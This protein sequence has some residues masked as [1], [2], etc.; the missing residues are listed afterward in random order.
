MIR[1]FLETI[2]LPGEILGLGLVPL[3]LVRKRNPVS[4]VAWCLAVLFIPY[5]GALFFLVFGASR[6]KRRLRRKLYHRSQFLRL[7]VAQRSRMEGGAAGDS[8]AGMSAYA[9]RVGAAPD[10]T[11]NAVTLYEEGVR[12][13]EDK[14]AAIRAAQ[15]HVHASYFIL[16][17]DAAGAEFMDLLCAK[18]S[19]GVEVRL[20]VDAV[21]SRGADHLLARLRAAGGRAAL[22]MPSQ[23]LSGRFTVGLRNHGKI[24]VCDG[25]VGFVGGLNVGDEYLGRVPRF[26]RWRDTHL[27]VAGPAVLALQRVF[28]ED[29]DFA[30]GELLTGDSYFPDPG[31]EGEAHVQVI[32]SGPDQEHNASRETFFA[33]ITAARRRLWIATPYLVPDGALLAAIRSAALRGV[34]VRILTQSSPPDHWMT[35]WAGRYFWEELFSAGV[36]IHEYRRGMMHAKV[37]L[38]DGAWACVGSANLDIRSIRLNFEINV[39]LHTPALVAELETVFERDLRAAREVSPGT[40]RHRSWRAQL[41]ENVCRLFSPLL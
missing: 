29:W 14:F 3:V 8:W 32:W 13:F 31:M 35:Y 5:L 15:R 36:R 4:A 22:F 16:R 17:D 34:D 6:V 10:T 25:R 23:L 28:V 2:F 12:A 27:R 41:A 39:H 37:M 1:W 40:F 7:W 21:G 38:A 18:A 9:L 33:A 26:G 30:S 19:A 20:L 24:L 11:G